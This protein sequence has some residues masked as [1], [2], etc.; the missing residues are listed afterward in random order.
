MSSALGVA[1]N[2]AMKAV[3]VGIVVGL[4]VWFSTWAA[5]TQEADA[6]VQKQ[7]QEAERAAN[8]AFPKETR[9][10]HSGESCNDAPCWPRPPALQRAGCQ[11]YSQ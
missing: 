7:I 5:Q 2:F 3:N 4:I 6:A 10:C 1:R 11:L 9:R 8:R